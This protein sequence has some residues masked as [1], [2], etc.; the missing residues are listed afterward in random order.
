MKKFMGQNFLLDSLPAK[1]LYHNYAEKLPIIDYHCHLSPQEIWEDKRYETIT[2][3]W[4]GGDHYKWRLIRAM[5][6]E[7]PFVTG[8]AGD[9]E[10]FRAFAHALSKSIGNPLYH[11]AHLE[12][13]RYFGYHGVLNEETAD[14]VFDL[15]NEALADPSMSARNIILRSNVR[16]LCTTDDPVDDLIWHEKLVADDSF[17]VKVLPAFRPDKSLGIDK[18]GFASYIQTLGDVCDMKIRTMDDLKSALSKRLDFF[19]NHGCNL[20][21]HGLDYLVC[22]SS[23]QRSCDEILAAALDGQTITQQE[24]DQ[25]K[26]D[27]LVFLAGEY[28][29]RDWVMQIH[30]GVLRNVSSTAFKKLGPD[31]GFDCMGCYPGSTALASLLDRLEREGG[32]PKL[33]VYPIND[34]DNTALLTVLQAYQTSLPGR[35]QLGSA[36]WFNDTKTG[37]EKQLKDL[38]NNGVLGNFVGM[39]TDSRSFLSYTRHEYFRRILCNVVGGW[40]ENGELPWDEA[41]LGGIISDICF[42]NANQY[43]ELYV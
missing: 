7:E 28:N 13:K 8:D 25:Y 2:E 30:F 15:C 17:P 18:A 40:V 22:E 6:Y 32:V 5:G 19:A 34:M 3:A 41:W 11:W 20:S 38:A 26:T 21:D 24:A 29:R 37:M 43:F 4:L 36:W 1:H 10:K 27:L 12:L 35:L 42:H 33:I 39:L 16:A 31:T 9:R 14:Q 23:A